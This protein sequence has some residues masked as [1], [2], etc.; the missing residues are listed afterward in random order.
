M[1]RKCQAIRGILFTQRWWIAWYQKWG[2]QN[3][4]IAKAAKPGETCELS[5]PYFCVQSINN[6]AVCY[7][8]CL[9]TCVWGDQFAYFSPPPPQVRKIL[10]Q[11]SRMMWWQKSERAKRGF[12]DHTICCTNAISVHTYARYVL[13][14]ETLGLY[15]P[16]NM[17]SYHR[18]SSHYT[19]ASMTIFFAQL[20]KKSKK[21]KS[22]DVRN[23]SMAESR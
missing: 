3:G 5:S 20:A 17:L 8:A 13:H 10:C 15:F 16:Q 12:I 19:F 1:A 4:K 21:E 2:C 7:I 22:G 9:V 23:W 14:G 11:N 6:V 18:H